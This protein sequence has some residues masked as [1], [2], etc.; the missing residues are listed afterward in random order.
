MGI[1]LGGE[2]YHGFAGAT[3]EIGHI[4]MDPDGGPCYCGNNGCLEIYASSEAVLSRCE[5]AAR[6]G[7]APGSRSSSRGGSP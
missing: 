3:G 4:T 7:D 1:I 5:Q 6:M 2:I